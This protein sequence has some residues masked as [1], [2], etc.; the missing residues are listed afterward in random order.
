MSNN[1]INSKILIDKIISESY[2]NF[3]CLVIKKG[4]IK[5]VSWT[6]PNYAEKLMEL[7]LFESIDTNPE[8]F[9]HTLGKYLELNNFKISNIDIKNEIV[10]EEPYYLYEL[11]YINLEKEKEYI[12]DTNL[13]EMASLININGDQIYSNAI[14]FRTH[15]PSLSNSMVFCN[16][17]KTDLQRI[18]HERVYTKIVIYDEKWMEKQ[19]VGDLNE[20]AEIFFDNNF[21]KLELPFL[22]H[23]INIWYS[24]S[25]EGNNN[26]CGNL[27]DDSIDKCIIFSMKSEEYRG[28]LTYDEVKKIIYLSTKMGIYQTPNELL[29]EKNDEFGRKIIYNK[30]KVLDYTYN[31]YKT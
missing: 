31:K 8:N 23:N 25:Q 13:N 9:P 19:V 24:V 1:K 26:L 22:M 28:N 15:I 6:L 30:Y 12:N 5:S 4:S 17:E 3:K 18:L 10:A 7:D 21:E 29:E 27:I 2:N 14:L 11:C 16:L 20:F